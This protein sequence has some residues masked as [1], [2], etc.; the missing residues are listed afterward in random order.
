TDIT[1]DNRAKCI[2]GIVGAASGNLVEWFDFY[3]YAVFAA[4]FTKALTPQNMDPLTQSIYVW[5]VFAASFFMR[6]IGSWLFGRI[7]DRHGRKRSMVASIYLMGF[8]SFLFA[9]LP[10]LCTSRNVCAITLTAS[11]LVTR[12]I[13]WW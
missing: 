12:I 13:C 2:R 7:A 1:Q 8:S 10:H 3:I 4:Y 11:S 5:G 6:P 9:A